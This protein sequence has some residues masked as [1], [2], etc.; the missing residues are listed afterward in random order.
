[1]KTVA[2]QYGFAEGPKIA[3]KFIASLRAEGWE[4]A[5]VEKADIIIAHSGG[6]RAIANES[7]AKKIL[8]VNIS[9]WPE[10]GIFGALAK[11]IASEHFNVNKLFWNLWYGI[12]KISYASTMRGNYSLSPPHKTIVIRNKNDTYMPKKRLTELEA[13]SYEII[14]LPGTHDD[15]WDNPKSYIHLINSLR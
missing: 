1:M 4:L 7:S 6:C 15:I 11:K 5:P 14:E 10:V 3:N 12:T 2:I 8:L 13:A 9:P